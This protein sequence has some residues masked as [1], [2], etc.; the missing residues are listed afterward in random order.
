MILSKY[1]E[2]QLENAKYEYDPAADVWCAWVPKLPGAYAQG[3]SVEEARKEL[4]E[5]IEEYLLISLQK[6]KE[7]KLLFKK[8]RHTYA[9]A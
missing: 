4:T 1:I 8:I 7:G 5:V 3:S 2:K 6:E 9:T